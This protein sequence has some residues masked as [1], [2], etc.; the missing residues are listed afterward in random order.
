MRW[1]PA[2]KRCGDGRYSA[3]SIVTVVII[4]PP[5][6][7]GERVEELTAPVEGPD[8]GGCEHLVPGEGRE[9]DAEA[10]EGEGHVGRGLARVEDGEGADLAREG[11][12]LGH[13]RDGAEH[14]RRVGKRDHPGTR[15]DDLL[16]D[17]H[18]E[19]A[20]VVDRDPPQ[21]RPGAEGELLPRDEIRVVLERRHD[22]LVPGPDRERLDRVP[23][24]AAL[25]PDGGVSERV[26]DEV[27]RLG[28]V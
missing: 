28:G 15:A 22:D 2:S 27:Q 20:G 10:A 11:H 16:R 18:A 26:G 4:E 19:P 13:G 14:V 6:R 24:T 5:T 9:V 7:N 17:V 12:E 21:G 8:A 25:G 1:V 3:R 23:S